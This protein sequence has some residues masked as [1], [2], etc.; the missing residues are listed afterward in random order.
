MRTPD[1][2]GG[3]TLRGQLEDTEQALARA[4]L[5]I[6]ALEQAID[7]RDQEHGVELGRLQDEAARIDWRLEV[8]RAKRTVCGSIDND[9]AQARCARGLE[10]RMEE[11]GV[12]RHYRSCDFGLDPDYRFVRTRRGEAV[13]PGSYA[14]TAP[15]SQK[16]DGVPQYGVWA[17]SFCAEPA[18]AARV[19]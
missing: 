6:A 9:A 16:M 15:R 13:A 2:G 3:L 12:R 7:G 18:S 17:V 4:R 5:R 8:S 19:Y 1:L 14:L 10:Q 11:E